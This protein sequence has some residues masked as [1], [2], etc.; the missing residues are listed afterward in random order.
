MK[1]INKI[2]QILAIVCGAAALVLFFTTFAEIVSNG[3]VFSLSGTQLSFGGKL[4]DELGKLS[5]SAHILFC[6]WLTVLATVLSGFAIKKKGARYAAPAFSLTVAIYMLVILLK[7]ARRFVDVRPL[8]NVTE[9][10]FTLS[11]VLV[12]IAL[13]VMFA[14]SLA[15]LLL[16]D[17]ITVKASNGKLLTIFQRIVKFFR[18]YKSEIKKIVWPGFSDVVK[19]TVIVLIMCLVVGIFIWLVDL[20]LG[21]LIKLILKA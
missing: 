19:N 18:D 10:K 6:F 16:D 15:H 17:Y 2:C 21:Q 7:G 20:G 9:G 13:F 12:V 5:K 4:S 11:V 14:T 1:A 3:T 8:T